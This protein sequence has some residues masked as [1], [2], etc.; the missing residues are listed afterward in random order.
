MENQ[1]GTI[2][3]L[4]LAAL[5]LKNI[6]LIILIAVIC[7]A[8]GF[9][10]SKFVISKQYTASAQIAVSTT[11]ATATEEDAL[12]YNDI[13]AAIQIMNTCERL[14]DGDSMVDL[15]VT[16]LKEKYGYDYTKNP[17]YI[18][19]AISPTSQE[20]TMIMD[21]VVTTTDPELS[22]IIA[23]L[24]QENA[25]TVYKDVIEQ[26]KVKAVNKA[27]IPLSPSSPNVRLYTAA[28][29]L[30]G[31]LISIIIVFIKNALSKKIRPSDDLYRLYDIP[32][33]AEIMDFNSIVKGG[34][35]YEYSE[36]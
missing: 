9:S 17:G 14:F 12:N 3:L 29:M 26:G 28:G 5:L 23:N 6:K 36:K 20:D 1:E 2:D 22:A 15:V 8:A 13:N 21:I 18:K 27:N 33:F 4:D 32:V 35:S 11:A 16:Q 10:L 7:G 30:L 19:S 31:A 25:N 34:Y 24:V